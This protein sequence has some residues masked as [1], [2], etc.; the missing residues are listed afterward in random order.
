MYPEIL[1][2]IERLQTELANAGQSSRIAPVVAAVAQIAAE[3]RTTVPGG[4]PIPNRDPLPNGRNTPE[5]I[6]SC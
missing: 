3:L 5:F 2:H 1:H 4:H 6:Q